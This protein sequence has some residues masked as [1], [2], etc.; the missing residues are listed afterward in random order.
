M[1]E[2]VNESL[3][4]PQAREAIQRYTSRFVPNIAHDWDIVLNEIYPIIQQ[5][6]ATIYFR[7]PRV[8]LKPRSKFF[9]AKKLNPATGMKEEVF[10]D[11]EKSAK[12]QEAILNYTL[13]EIGYKTEIRRCLFDAL[14]LKHGVLW[15]GFKGDFGMTEEQSLTIKNEKVFVKRLSPMQFIFDP[16]VTIANLDEAAWIGRW[17]MVPREDILEDDK[18]DVDKKSLKGQNGFGLKVVEEGIERGND[19]KSTAAGMMG[20]Q[21]T[22]LDFTDNQF[23]QSALSKFIKVYEIMKRPTKKEIRDNKKGKVILYTH[24]QAEPLRVSAWPYKAEG[25]NVRVL[26]FNEIVDAMFGMS[27]LEVYGPIVDQKNAVINLQLRNA[28]E[29]S[30][31]WVAIAKDGANEEDLDKVKVGDQTV[32]FLTV[33]LLMERCRSHQGPEPLQVNSTA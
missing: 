33:I 3:L 25:W 9:T 15:H 12:T 2:K 14:L 7:N 6:L 11:S 5:E 30:K 8:F 16:A 1:A 19:L 4:L 31:L 24:E 17:F 28:Q 13:S 10:L 20:Q 23:R 29:N 26:Q 21:R 32:I 22:I 27:D 18:L